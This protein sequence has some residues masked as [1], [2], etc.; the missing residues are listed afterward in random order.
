MQRKPDRRKRGRALA[1]TGA[2]VLTSL[3]ALIAA[4]GSSGSPWRGTAHFAPTPGPAQQLPR[5]GSLGPG[6]AAEPAPATEQ[7]GVNIGLLFSLR[8]YGPARIQAQLSALAKTGASLVRT[9]APWEATEDRK[10]V[11]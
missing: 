7:L 6:P 4:I 11:V 2:L 3:V 9:D 5:A 8:S 1:T 10:S